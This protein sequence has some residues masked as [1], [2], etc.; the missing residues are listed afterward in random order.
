MEKGKERLNEQ[1]KIAMPAEEKAR[2]VDLG[3]SLN[4]RPE[5]KKW[6]EKIEEDVSTQVVSDTSGQPVLQPAAPQ[7]P[8]VQLPATRK[9]FVTGFKK[10]IEDAGR[11]LS[12]FILRLIKIN[13]GNV[14]FKEE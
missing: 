4:V 9:T 6:M 2:I 5:I 13:K 14:K 12:V 10:K 7:N 11:W 8:K 3:E 1:E